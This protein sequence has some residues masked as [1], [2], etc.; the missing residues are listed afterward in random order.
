MSDLTLA[1]HRKPRGSWPAM[2]QKLENE[3]VGENASA[4][5]RMS[6]A[7]RPY[8]APKLK[9]LGS[10]RELTLGSSPGTAETGGTRIPKAK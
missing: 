8:H 2:T 3:A 5:P 7:K 10:V 6:A 4:T 9:H 1:S